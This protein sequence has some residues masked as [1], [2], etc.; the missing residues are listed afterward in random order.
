MGFVAWLNKTGS[1]NPVHNK[2][3]DT[4]QVQGIHDLTQID[5]SEF[6][7][8]L[9]NL[10]SD[11]KPFPYP[12]SG[13]VIPHHLLAGSMI[14]E[15]LEQVSAQAPK[16]IVLIGPNHFEK[17]EKLILTSLYGW[18]TPFGVLQPNMSFY[19]KLSPGKIIGVD[20]IVLAKEHTVS[21]LVTYINYFH[22]TTTFQ[23]L[24]ISHQI[25]MSDIETFSQL[26]NSTADTN[27]LFVL[28]VDFS[29]YLNSEQAN[30]RDEVS[31]KAIKDFDFEKIALFS[32]EYVDSP[33][34]LLLF[35]KIMQLRSTKNVEV[36]QHTN[37]GILTNDPYVENTSYFT[38]TFN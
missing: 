38:L 21:G 8:Q 12:V 33:K 2:T 26:L 31:L 30:Q 35:L 28:S 37:S 29:H 11:T 16:T 3:T 36:V 10:P 25:S 14:A 24:I 23:P 15:I 22:P 13:I 1:R 18:K 9:K 19:S 34:S 32:N 4:F 27:T 20:E 17:G 6:Y 5:T 7:R